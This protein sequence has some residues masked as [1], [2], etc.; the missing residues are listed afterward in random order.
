V[1]QHI[2]DRLRQLKQ[3][4]ALPAYVFLVLG[5]WSTIEFAVGKIRAFALWVPSWTLTLAGVLWLGYLLL[6]PAR[7]ADRV[8][9]MRGLLR[10]AATACHAIQRPARETID[11]ASALAL[12]DLRLHRFLEMGFAAYVARDYDLLREDER[13]RW[14]QAGTTF[15]MELISAD[16]L[17]RLAARLTA[18]DLDFGFHIPQSYEQFSAANTWQP[19]TRPVRDGESRRLADTIS[20]S[21]VPDRSS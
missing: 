4:A 8:E 11:S 17:D 5:Y 3:R 20:D 18:D 1:P 14:Q 9:E 13:E 12:K 15:R 19:N 10:E 2:A 7:G 21:R 6:R 16:F